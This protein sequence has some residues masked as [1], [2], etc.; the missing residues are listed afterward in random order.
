[1]RI[2]RSVTGIAVVAACISAI[3]V[4]WAALAT[5]QQKT[6]GFQNG[7]GNG[8]HYLF[9]SGW[10][11]I[12][13]PPIL[14]ALAFLAVLWW[15]HQC[16]VTGCHWYA[17]RKTAAG[18]LACFRHHPHRTRTYQDILDAHSEAL[19]NGRAQR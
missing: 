8:S 4:D 3:A 9:V 6:F 14:N 1:M 10:G 11:S 19:A 16:H 15:H 7:G 2:L 13:L 12:I 17:R 18:E 5:W